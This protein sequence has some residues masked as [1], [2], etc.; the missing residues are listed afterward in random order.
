MKLQLSPVARVLIPVLLPLIA[1]AENNQT[2]TLEFEEL[3]IIAQKQSMERQ[4]YSRSGA[5]SSISI[6]EDK[7]MQSLDSVVRALAGSYTNIN[8]TQGTVSINIRGESGFGRVNTMVDGV[9]QAFYGTSANSDGKYHSE[10]NGYGPTS[11]FGTMISPDFLV[12]A[13]IVR[14]YASGAGGVNG[15]MGHANL[16]TFDVDDVLINDHQVGILSKWQYGTNQIGKGGMLTLAG[17]TSILSQGEVGALLGYSA[18]T[19]GANYKTGS[20]VRLSENMAVKK[21]EQKPTA[22]L[23]KLEFSPNPQH[24]F[25]I[26]YNQF[27]NNVGGREIDNRA[28]QLK[29]QYSPATPLLNISFL[30]AKTQS[31]QRFNEDSLIWLL[32]KGRTQNETRYLNLQNIAIISLLDTQTSFTLGASMFDNRYEKSAVGIDQDNLEHTTFSP[33]GTQKLQSIYAESEV[34]K[35]IVLFNSGL[36]YTVGE[37]RGFKSACRTYLVES[38]KRIFSQNCVPTGEGVM[39][40][41]SSALNGVAMLTL[42]I[43]DGFKPFVSYSQNTRVPNVQEVFFNNESASSMNPFLKPEEVATWQWGFNSRKENVLQEGDFLGL[44]V[45]GYQARIKNYIHSVS[46]YLLNDGG[47]TRNIH[48]DLAPAAFH[49]QMNVNAIKPVTNKGIEV[50]VHYDS[51]NTFASMTYSYQKTNHHYNASS[52]TGTGFG[53][54]SVTELPRDYA[55]LDVGGRALNKK[56]TFGGI[57]KYTGKF[58]RYSPEGLTVEEQDL[59]QDVPSMPIIFDIY[60]HYQLNDHILLKATVQNVTNRNYIDALN[61]LNSTQSQHIDDSKFS[62]T[63]A[64]RGRTY[65][66]GTEIRF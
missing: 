30:A 48:G 36:T 24:Q 27:D 34:K 66:L 38:G 28:S 45:V 63:N 56:L 40:L 16:R 53:T 39:R 37:V 44:K 42:E 65:L 21:L 60:A 14:G 50:S 26:G 49:A 43:N 5:V 52:T 8:P 58:R 62:Y 29:Y 9:P 25:L 46:F 6:S 33:E 55:T 51:K 54:I 32:E 11:Q 4:G 64:A 1:W 61:A 18:K 17:K 20:G 2:L 23:A 31:K 19:I 47:L 41:H 35:G 59:L 15:L 13:D 7:R 10:E 57:A 22:Y 12:G 3:D